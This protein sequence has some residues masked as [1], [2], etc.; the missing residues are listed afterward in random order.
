FKAKESDDLWVR[1]PQRLHAGDSLTLTL[2]YHGDL[3]DRFQDWFFIDPGAAWY[4]RNQQGQNLATFDLTYHSPSWYP[5]ATVGDRLD[6]AVAGK[7]LTTH[8]VTRLPTSFASF[9]LGLFENYHFQQ[10][11]A[12]PLDVLLSE[13]AHRLLARTLA[14]QGLLIPQQRNMRE[15]VAVDVSNSLKLFAYLFGESAYGHFYVTE[16]PYAEGVSFPGMIDLSWVTFQETALDGFD[17]FF[18]AHE[19][20]HQWWGNGVRPGSYRDA[21]LSEGLASFSALW[22]LQTLP[23]HRDDYF[24]FLEKYKADIKDERDDAGPIWIGYRNATP[25]VRRGYD[26]VIYEK[27]AWVFHMLRTMMLDL[28]SVKDDR[29]TEMMRDYYSSYR[30]KPATTEDFKSVVEQ[31]IGAPMDWFFNQWV[32]GTTI[33]TYHVAWKSQPAPD[34]KY[35]VRLRVSQ[36]HVAPEFRMP[37]LVSADLGNNRFAHFR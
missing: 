22:Y 26:V 10:S 14:R 21:W 27:G 5:L 23:K 20:A 30:G 17:E 11:A 28:R 37:V 29:F 32:K 35:T 31:H 1:A 36:E 24:K 9:N 4:P 15:A 13:D 34:G 12:P 18:R 3:I 8:W 25:R 7:V 6:S 19:A 2:F 16:I 33:P